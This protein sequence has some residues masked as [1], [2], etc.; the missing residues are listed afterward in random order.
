MKKT[1]RK[2]ITCTILAL[3][4]FSAGCTNPLCEVETLY[5]EDSSQQND[6]TLNR[7][8]FGIITE[9]TGETNAHGGHKHGNGGSHSGSNS[10]KHG[11]GG[12]NNDR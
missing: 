9:G 7:S 5:E 8:V 10:H 6:T 12:C 1:I 3:T 4:F 11:D 2:I